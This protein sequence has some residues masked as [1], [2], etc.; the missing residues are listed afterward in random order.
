[1]TIKLTFKAGNTNVEIEG[2]V[3]VDRNAAE[4]LLSGVTS[5]AGLGP[6]ILAKVNEVQQ[7]AGAVAISAAATSTATP[8]VPAA[9]AATAPPGGAAT[10]A[11]NCAV[12]AHGPMNDTLGKVGKNGQPYRFRY[13]CGADYNDPTKC[14][15]GGGRN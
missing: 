6:Q 12:P 14:A 9:A 5:L 15:G 11:P 10:T 4:D 1:M 13:Y 7:A 3:D 2:D 8:A